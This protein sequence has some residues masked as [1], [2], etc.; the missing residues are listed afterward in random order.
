MVDG[1]RQNI[2][3]DGFFPFEVMYSKEPEPMYAHWHSQ[4]ELMFFYETDGCCYRCRDKSIHV[5]KHDL[6]VANSA[7][8]HECLDF[9]N[10]SVCCV[11]ADVGM[12]GE[13]SGETIE[14]LVRSDGR[15]VGLFNTM[16]SERGAKTHALICA[17]C[18]CKVLSVLIEDHLSCRASGEKRRENKVLCKSTQKMLEFIESNLSERLKISTL[19]TAFHMSEGRLAHVFKETSGVSPGEYIEK[20]RLAAAMKMLRETEDGISEIVYKCGFS[21]HSYFSARFK[22]YTGLSPRDYRK[23]FE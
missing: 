16:L 14:N 20:A 9:K 6:I 10:A 4:L 15:I 22:K 12:L 7:E 5:K 11:I 19:A 1:V 2:I 17:S 23:K 8:V 21:D 3:H 18:I 13:Y